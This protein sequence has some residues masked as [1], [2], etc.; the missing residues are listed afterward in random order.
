M[1]NLGQYLLDTASNAVFGP[2]PEPEDEQ[3][4][5]SSVPIYSADRYKPTIQDVLSV[6]EDLIKAFH[7]PA[8]LVDDVVDYAEYWPHTTTTRVG[9]EVTITTFRSHDR[10]QNQ[11]LVS[12]IYPFTVKNV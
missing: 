7:L 9:G 12:I 3:S 4:R 6:K 2:T 11:L 1:W 10:N 8:E 5:T